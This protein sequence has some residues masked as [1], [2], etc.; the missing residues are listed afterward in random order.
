MVECGWPGATAVAGAKG[1]KIGGGGG[2]ALTK[3]GEGISPGKGKG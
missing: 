2:V 3:G 1:E